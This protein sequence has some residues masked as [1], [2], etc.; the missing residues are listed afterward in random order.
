[1]QKW[2]QCIS[3]SRFSSQNPFGKSSKNQGKRGHSSRV[4]GV[5]SFPTFGNRNPQKFRLFFQ[6]YTYFLSYNMQ[7]NSLYFIMVWIKMQWFQS[8][9]FQK[10]R[11]HYLRDH[12]L[13]CLINDKCKKFP[14]ILI[15]F[16]Y[17]SWSVTQKNER[18]VV[19]DLTNC[20]VCMHC[21]LLIQ[22][23]VCEMHSKESQG[24]EWKWKC[25]WE[26]VCRPANTTG[27]H[28]FYT[29]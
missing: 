15:W 19:E 20:H 6:V 4:H 7:P 22:L 28:I 27:S 5:G 3:L 12:Y 9:F 13:G 16:S 1:M 21:Q 8:S 10:S 2:P 11:R 14:Q 25:R 29:K 24:N 23:Y 18:K 26:N 17:S